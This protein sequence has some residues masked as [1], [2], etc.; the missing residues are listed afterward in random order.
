MNNT[1]KTIV[2]LVTG[3]YTINSI[4]KIK[5]IKFVPTTLAYLIPVQYRIYVKSQW[6]YYIS[7]LED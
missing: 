1:K 4:P 2:I 5:L 3:Q 7:F 6:E